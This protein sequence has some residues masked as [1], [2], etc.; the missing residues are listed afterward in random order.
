MVRLPFV[1]CRCHRPSD[2]L[3]PVDRGVADSDPALSGQA[4]EETDR[5]SHLTRFEPPQERG[6]MIRAF[7]KRLTSEDRDTRV[8][9]A[10]AWSIWEAATSYLQVNEEN[11]HKWGEE[12]FA[13]AVARIERSPAISEGPEL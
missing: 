13:I 10:R 5:H 3:D 8:K 11:V 4:C 6:D 2:P 1:W 9:A 7:Y 12:D